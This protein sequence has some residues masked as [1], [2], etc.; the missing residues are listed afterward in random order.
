MVHTQYTQAVATVPRVTRSPVSIPQTELE[1]L[2]RTPTTSAPDVQQQIIIVP[3]TVVQWEWILLSQE[4]IC[5]GTH[6]G[7][8]TVLVTLQ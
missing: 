4:T 5:I 2:W 3:G 6:Y 8:H 1:N 7:T